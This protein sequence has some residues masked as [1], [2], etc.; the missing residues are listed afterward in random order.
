MNRIN[1]TPAKTRTALATIAALTLCLVFG[2]AMAD[3]HESQDN[4]GDSI[5]GLWNVIFSDPSGTPFLHAFVAFHSDQTDTQTDTGEPTGILG[6]NVC[7]GVWVMLH[8]GGIGDAHPFYGFNPKTGI[9][10]GTSGA[11]LET[12]TLDKGGQ[13]F[14][15]KVTV[16]TVNGLDPFDPAAMVTSTL[17][18]SLHGKRVTVDTSKLP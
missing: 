13:T 2:R 16:I 11:E 17:T 14:S 10:D 7:Q 6:G 3:G 9:S 1:A 8:D 5:V 4:E 12:I 15:G 18:G